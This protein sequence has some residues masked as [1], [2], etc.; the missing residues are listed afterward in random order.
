ME[1]AAHGGALTPLAGEEH[2][3]LAAG[4]GAERSLRGRAASRD[5]VERLEESSVIRGDDG[6]P[7]VEVR[8][9]RSEGEREVDRLELGVR[10]DVRP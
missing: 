6:A 4:D 1:R 2:G 5:A 8:P 9:R 3:E 10:L 7:P